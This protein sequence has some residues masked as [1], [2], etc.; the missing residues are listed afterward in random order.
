MYLGVLYYSYLFVFMGK[1]IL[2]GWY[3]EGDFVEEGYF[4]MWYVLF[5]GNDVFLYFKIYVVKFLMVFINVI[6]KDYFWI[7]RIGNYWIYIF[8]VS[9]VEFVGV[10]FFGNFYDF[11]VDYVYFEDLFNFVVI[12]LGFVGVVYVGNLLKEEEGFFWNFVRNGGMVVWVFEGS[13]CFFGVCGVMECIDNFCLSFDVFNVLI[14]VFFEYEGMFW[15]G[16]VF[17]N[18]MLF[19]LVGDKVIIGLVKFGNGI[20]YFVGGNFLYYSFYWNLKKEVELIFGFVGIDGSLNYM[21]FFRLDG[22]Y[23]FGFLLL[24]L[25]FV[26]IFESYYFYWK[27]RVNGKFVEL[28]RDDCM[29]FMLIIVLGKFMVDVEFCDLFMCFRVYFVI[30]WVF[31][32]VYFLVE[33]FWRCRLKVV[34]NELS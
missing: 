6:V 19:F 9:F 32:F 11:L 30:G 1:F 18:V 2:N 3:Y 17:E 8:N 22:E 7:E 10:V 27:I 29:G 34:I 5:I 21:F 26:W 12:L 28:I 25:M 15:Y 33:F 16:F 23:L 13:G 31:V 4:R 24:R 14:F 20:F